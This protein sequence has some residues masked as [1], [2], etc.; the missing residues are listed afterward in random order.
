MSSSLTSL[1]ELT[2]KQKV[3]IGICIILAFIGGS[4]GMYAGIKFTEVKA[5]AEQVWT[6]HLKRQDNKKDNGAPVEEEKNKDADSKT[7]AFVPSREEKQPE[8][9]ADTGEATPPPAPGKIEKK[10]R[11]TFK[12][13]PDLAVAVAKAENRGMIPNK[14]GDGHL[15]F[16]Q[17]GITYGFSVGIFQIRYLP[18]RPNPEELKNPDFNIKYAYEMFKGSGWSPWT[19]FRNEEYKKFL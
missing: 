14:I 19:Q 18:G 6:E 5:E 10:I 7:E 17:D 16:Q 13:C 3:L 9:V 4:A 2:R 12:D 11:K 8:K 15:T 1:G